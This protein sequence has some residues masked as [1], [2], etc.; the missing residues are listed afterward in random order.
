MAHQVSQLTTLATS[1]KHWL[2]ERIWYVTDH[3]SNILKKCK[4]KTKEGKEERKCI[5]CYW[6]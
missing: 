3:T 4:T 5:R 2:N 6:G 1:P